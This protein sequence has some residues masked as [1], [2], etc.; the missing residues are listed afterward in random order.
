MVC[1]AAAS[2]LATMIFPV[3]VVQLAVFECKENMMCPHTCDDEWVSTSIVQRLST[4]LCVL[5]ILSSSYENSKAKSFPRRR[6]KEEVQNL[7]Y[8]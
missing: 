3:L 1:L 4:K 8:T 6:Q 5:T 7:Y 2:C